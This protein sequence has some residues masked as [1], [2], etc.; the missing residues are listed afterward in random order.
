MNPHILFSLAV[1]AV[2]FGLILCVSISTMY[3]GLTLPKTLRGHGGVCA[4][5]FYPV[6]EGHKGVCP[7]CGRRYE[8]AGILTPAL[9]IK[10][11]PT[12]G[13][14]VISW[15]FI[16]LFAMVASGYAVEIV[17]SAAGVRDQIARWFARGLVVVFVALFAWGI[18]WINRRRRAVFAQS[19]DSGEEA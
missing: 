11:R 3:K 16:V 8:E 13:S 18:V 17:F 15:A 10:M 5:C 4:S 7:E 6:V 1:P 9:S 12:W 2:L 14:V 19:S